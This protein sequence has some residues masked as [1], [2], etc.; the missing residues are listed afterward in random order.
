VDEESSFLY[1]QFE[2]N[3]LIRQSFTCHPML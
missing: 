3:V 2:L 1:D